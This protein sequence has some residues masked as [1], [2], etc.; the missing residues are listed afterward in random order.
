[1]VAALAL[2]VADL[3][4][5]HRFERG[6]LYNVWG[7]RGPTIGRKSPGEYRIAVLGGSAAYGFGVRWEESMPTLLEQ[8]LAGERLHVP[9]G[10]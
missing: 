6:V 5:H 4:A 2:V 10:T 3:Y 7:Y 8:R 1:M 9:L